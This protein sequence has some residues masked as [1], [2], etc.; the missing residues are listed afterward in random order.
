MTAMMSAIRMSDDPPP[1][2]RA[3]CN[4]ISRLHI[5]SSQKINAIAHIATAIAAVHMPKVR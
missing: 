2:A 1:I 4:V 5:P 3:C